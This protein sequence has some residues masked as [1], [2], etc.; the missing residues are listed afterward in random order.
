MLL[1]RWPCSIPSSPTIAS[2]SALRGSY[3]GDAA[4]TL[5]RRAGTR[6]GAPWR[7]CCAI[8]VRAR[9]LRGR[10]AG[11][12]GARGAS[13]AIRALDGEG[14]G[15]PPRPELV[16]ARRLPPRC[17]WCEARRRFEAARCAVTQAVPRTRGSQAPRTWS[18]SPGEPRCAR[19]GAPG[20]VVAS[21][22]ADRQQ[23][24]GRSAAGIS[25]AWAWDPPEGGSHEINQ[26][27][28]SSPNL[29][30]LQLEGHALQTCW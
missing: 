22:G 4:D 10:A 5:D 3:Q 26:T 15:S 21:R 12:D 25:S 16:R 23:N 27:W 8:R 1:S 14:S 2:L 30:M 9:E 13:D 11:A 28:H 6:R 19:L 20:T 17:R 18:V 29:W 7:R 24:P